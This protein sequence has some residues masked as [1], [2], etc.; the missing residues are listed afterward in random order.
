MLDMFN[1]DPWQAI[2]FG[3][4]LAANP[5]ESSFDAARLVVLFALLCVY[6][7]FLGLFVDS[8]VS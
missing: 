1:S 4:L 2:T 3:R 6:T 8:S 7:C 5:V